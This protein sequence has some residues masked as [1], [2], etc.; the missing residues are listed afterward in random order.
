[1][2]SWE[3]EHSDSEI[4]MA[5]FTKD[6]IKSMQ[7]LSLHL[8]TI[9]FSDV[10][11]I[12]FG[13]GKGRVLIQWNELAPAAASISGI[14]IDRNLYVTAMDNLKKLDLLNR[15]NIYNMDAAKFFA[16][17]DDNRWSDQLVLFFYNPFG[18]STMTSILDTLPNRD[19]WAI[20]FNDIHRNLFTSRGFEAIHES[21]S[22]R[23]GSSY[24]ILR[25]SC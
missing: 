13:C 8:S 15:V 3:A 2:V 7:R 18:Q 10:D 1:M 14:E 22:Y 11:L 16:S 6:V 21:K 5:T 19:I 4:Y 9:E 25:R 20:Y 23:K 24:C 17:H 12:D